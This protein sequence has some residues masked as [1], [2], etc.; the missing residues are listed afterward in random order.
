MNERLQLVIRYVVISV[1]LFC[2]GCSEE[3]G[4][5]GSILVRN[6]ILDREYNRVVIDQVTGTGGLL[7]FRKELSPGEKILL[8]QK[9]ITEIRFSRKYKDLTR[10]YIVKCPSDRK[11]GIL[12]KLIDVHTNRM[13]GGCKMVRKGTQ[14]NGDVLKWEK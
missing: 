5:P 11:E 13:P 6:D 4:P 10:Y 3:K 1:I 14:E 7:P 9:G 12:L 2:L 8:Q